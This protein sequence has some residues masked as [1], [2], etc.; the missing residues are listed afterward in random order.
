MVLGT[1]DEDTRTNA[2]V[3]RLRVRA[4]QFSRDVSFS[5]I[6]TYT[7]DKPSVDV[8]CYTRAD[9]TEAAK[10]FFGEESNGIPIRYTAVVNFAIRI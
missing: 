1:A 6:L 2:E 4:A 8:H 10:E 9:D 7:A 3:E 5:R